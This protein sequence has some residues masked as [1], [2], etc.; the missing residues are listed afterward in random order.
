[1]SQIIEIQL[2]GHLVYPN[3]VKLYSAEGRLAAPYQ[4]NGAGIWQNGGLRNSPPWG[5][6]SEYTARCCYPL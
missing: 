5:L 2:H 3:L 6:L 1:M 4:I